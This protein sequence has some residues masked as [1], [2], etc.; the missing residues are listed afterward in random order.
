MGFYTGDEAYRV[1]QRPV[2]TTV[3]NPEIRS[4]K[5][6]AKDGRP[7]VA[8]HDPLLRRLRMY[9]TPRDKA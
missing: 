2:K 9:H 3:Q 1:R 7:R 5:L 6:D 4:E 8:E